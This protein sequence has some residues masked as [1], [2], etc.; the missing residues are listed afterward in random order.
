M[1]RDKARADLAAKLANMPSPDGMTPAPNG[2]SAAVTIVP[3]LAAAAGPLPTRP[4]A[5]LAAM[6]TEQ[7][8]V[9]APY[10]MKGALIELTGKAKGG[11]TSWLAYEVGCVIHGED[12]L[13]APTIKTGVVWL[14]EERP[15]TF[16]A[17]LARAGLLNA[18]NLL[19]VSK[20]DVPPSLSWP[21][22]V[23]AAQRICEATSSG[24]LIVDTLPAWAGLTGDRENNSG[25]ALEAL[26]PLQRAAAG[27]LAVVLVRHDRKGGGTVGESG[28]GSS[29]FAGAVDTLLHIGRPEGHTD[30][31]Q[32]QLDAISR[33]DGVPD[34]VIV[35]R[36]IPNAFPLSPT[37]S[38]FEKHFYRALGAPGPLAADAAL[39]AIL[40]TLKTGITLTVAELKTALPHLAP[41]AI[42][43]ALSPVPAQVER[44]GGGKKGSPYAYRLKAEDSFQTSNPVGK[45]EKHFL[46][47]TDELL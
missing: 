25:D 6:T 5:E 22:T 15:A 30:P 7:P 4:P 27:G 21:L 33:F 24:V 10:I 23:Q 1:D 47:A 19:I 31:N 44:T 34:S 46:D 20:W 11:K 9:I 12:C 28:R 42:T 29:A 40:D 37:G 43:K 13:G 3:S 32:R 16:R 41:A 38:R 39:A 8:E 17:A 18:P 36:A 35:E 2:T 26:D 14:T 45:Q